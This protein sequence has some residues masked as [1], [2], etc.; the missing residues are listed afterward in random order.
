M[1]NELLKINTGETFYTH[2]IDGRRYMHIGAVHHHANQCEFVFMMGKGVK[3]ILNESELILDENSIIIIPPMHIH[4]FKTENNVNEAFE[5]Y[6]IKLDDKI[7]AD[8]DTIDCIG[9]GLA[10]KVEENSLYHKIFEKIDNYAKELNEKDFDDMIYSLMK[11]VLYNIKISM[12]NNILI[13]KISTSINAIISDTISYI[14]DNYAT[15]TSIAEIAS[16]LYVSERYL[17]KLF[18]MHLSSSPKKVLMYKRLSEA[19]NLIS[20]GVKS[21]EACYMAGFSDYTVFYR[22]YKKHF[23]YPP[24]KQEKYA[25][26]KNK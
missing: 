19:K 20:K 11:E 16:K 23:G 15:I 17:S 21:N 12:K 8:T 10:I 26:N 5:C 4:A 3:Y 24:S 25:A 7:L 2:V 14:Y 18:S 9:E 13:P 22:N 6:T 1:F